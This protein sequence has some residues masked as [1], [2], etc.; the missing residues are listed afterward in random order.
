MSTHALR[1]SF[2][3]IMRNKGVADKTIMSI[4]GHKDIK[5]FNMYHQV[6]DSAR[7]NAVN[8]VFW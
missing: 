3:I 1:R 4:S 6:N 7:A 5:T 8:S 2:I